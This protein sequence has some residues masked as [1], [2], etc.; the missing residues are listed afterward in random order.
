VGKAIMIKL[1]KT[2]STPPWFGILHMFHGKRGHERA[3]IVM[4]WKAAPPFSHSE[5]V[6]SDFPPSEKWEKRHRLFFRNAPP[7]VCW[8]CRINCSL[9]TF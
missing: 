9:K 2:R 8:K 3:R 7:S 1:E 6:T 4:P 5:A